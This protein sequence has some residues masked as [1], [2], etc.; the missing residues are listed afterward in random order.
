MN[1]SISKTKITKSVMTAVSIFM[2]VLFAVTGN[3]S[4][5]LLWFPV[6]IAFQRL[7]EKYEAGS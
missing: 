2:G 3:F 6:F 7:V 4:F 1:E 5:L